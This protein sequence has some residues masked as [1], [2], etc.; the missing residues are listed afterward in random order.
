[1]IYER[2]IKEIGGSSMIIIPTDLAKYLGLT[3]GKI[4]CMQDDIGKH[5]KFLSM[6]N[7]DCGKKR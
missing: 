4:V 1:M 7:K 2:E 6:W 3:A 5:G